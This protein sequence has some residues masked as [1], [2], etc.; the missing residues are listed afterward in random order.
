MGDIR[1]LTTFSRMRGMLERKGI[2][3]GEERTAYAASNHVLGISEIQSGKLDISE[4]GIFYISSD[5]RR[6]RGYLYPLE[7][8]ESSYPKAHI[9]ECPTLLRDIRSAL[10]V[11]RFVWAN[12]TRVLVKKAGSFGLTEVN[13]LDICWDCLDA[14][15]GIRIVGFPRNTVAFVKKLEQDTADDLFKS[16]EESDVFGRPLDWHTVRSAYLEKVGYTCDRCG[17]SFRQIDL[18]PFVDV[19]PVDGRFTNR[20]FR[21][22]KC[23][24]VKCHHSIC[25]E[26]FSGE[27][28]Q[29]LYRLYMS[30]FESQEKKTAISILIASLSMMPRLIGPLCGNVSLQQR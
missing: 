5:G 20:Q 16:S 2:S 18:T 6:E 4:R 24:C 10:K 12:K 19:F 25:P 7:N 14:L 30:R 28:R 27:F 29:T 22:L 3:G 21:N 1:P 8:R 9:C 26:H 23:L 11:E 17:K 13:G 15:G